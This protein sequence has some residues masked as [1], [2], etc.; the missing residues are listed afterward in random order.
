MAIELGIVEKSG[1]FFSYGGTKIQGKDKTRAYFEEN[2]DLMDEL[3]AK[4]KSK[5]ANGEVADK[6][7]E[8]DLDAGDFDL[9]ALNLD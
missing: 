3:E 6:E 1:S 8:F 5:I 2:K 4:I 9:D 7:E